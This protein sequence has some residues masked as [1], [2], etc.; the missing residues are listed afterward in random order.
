MLRKNLEPCLL[1]P[2]LLHTLTGTLH[3][4]FGLVG[5]PFDKLLKSPH[6]AVMLTTRI[7]FLPSR[8][9]FRFFVGH[10]YGALVMRIL[11]FVRI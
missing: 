6:I 3:L 5:D 10:L 2:G 9:A 7:R 1:P 4:F 11:L 8:I